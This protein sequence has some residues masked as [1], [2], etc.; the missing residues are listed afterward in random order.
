MQSDN[1]NEAQSSSS[2]KPSGFKNKR[3][4]AASKGGIGLFTGLTGK[5]LT[6]ASAKLLASPEVFAQEVLKKTY[7]GDPVGN[8]FYIFF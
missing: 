4:E 5:P 1:R 6:V 7:V 8:Q 3:L 2:S